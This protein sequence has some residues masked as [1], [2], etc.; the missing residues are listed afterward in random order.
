[1]EGGAGRAKALP[2]IWNI[3]AKKDVFAV[4]SGKKLHDFW[5]P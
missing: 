1:L 3:A 4:S 5:S 2:W